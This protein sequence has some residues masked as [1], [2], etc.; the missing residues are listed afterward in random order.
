MG[1]GDCFSGEIDKINI[2]NA[3]FLPCIVL[4]TGCSYVRSIC[5][6]RQTV[7]RNTG[8]F[9][10]TTVVKGDGKYLSI[11]AASILAKTYRD[12]Y[13]N[14]LQMK[15]SLITTGIIPRDIPKKHRAA[16]AERGTTPYH[17][18]TF[19]L[20]GDGSWTSLF[21]NLCSNKSIRLDRRSMILVL[22]FD[23]FTEVIQVV[24][25]VILIFVFATVVC[26]R[27]HAF[28]YVD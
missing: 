15:S 5:Y 13:M 8:T 12:D 28:V 9:P 11:A 17:R 22:A 18:M 20:L 25:A 24:C 4:L 7:L 3:S 2:L 26:I 21:Y 10:H 14:R 16:I 19:N 1:G 6:R 23:E 27:I